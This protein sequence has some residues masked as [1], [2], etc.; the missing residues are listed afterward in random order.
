MICFAWSGFPQYAARCV[1][2]FVRSTKERVV[3]V[4]DRPAVPVR[5]MEELAHCE[6]CWIDLSDNRTLVEV[7]GEIPRLLMVSGWGCSLFN[8]YRDE[9]RACGGRVCAMSD[10]NLV[11]SL[12]EILKSLRF[13][14]LLAKKYDAYFVPGESG[15]R[16]MRFYGIPER[17]IV[18]GLYSADAS[19][20]CDKVPIIQRPRKLI[21]VGQFCDRKNVLAVCEAFVRVNQ[22]LNEKWEL[23]LCGCGPL[24][25]QIP[26]DANIVVRSFVQPEWLCDLYNEARVFVLASKEEHWGVVVHE[27]ALSG[28][29]LLL[30]DRVGASMDFVDD[31]NGVLFDPFDGRKLEFAMYDVL[32]ARAEDF[33]KAEAASVR[34]AKKCSLEAF[35]RGVQ[36]I[37]GMK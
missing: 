35:V 7:C 32:N 18:S 16:L 5:G 34:N 36:R 25:R 28:C 22:K 37:G 21:Y 23:V 3:V 8:R 29:Y 24:E 4:A 11:L 33:Q 14:L 27:A 13:R 9:V 31:E 17:K 2:A 12:R 1:G 15:R 20:F 26:R 10:N 6:V 30:S 19:L